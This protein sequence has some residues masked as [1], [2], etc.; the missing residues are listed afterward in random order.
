[1]SPS[2]SACHFG[3]FR[4]EP[5]E[6]R[7]L[8]DGRPV[9]LTPKMFETLR[10]LVERS[11]HLVVKEDLIQAVWRDTIVEDANLAVTI[12]AL[13]KALGCSPEHRYIQ[14]VSKVGYRFVAEVRRQR[15]WQRSLTVTVA[16]VVFG[17]AAGFAL[18]A[19]APPRRSQSIGGRGDGATPTPAVEPAS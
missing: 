11:G 12:S 8:R 5:T 18:V 17:L 6:H 9:P 2:D 16:C 15:P 7:L 1:M 13:R 4:F 10:V 19:G 14:T 3:P